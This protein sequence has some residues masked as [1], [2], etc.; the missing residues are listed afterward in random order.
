M[1][2]AKHLATTL[3]ADLEVVSLAA[4]LHDIAKPGMG[5]VQKHG[6]ASAE[7]AQEIL[8]K[9]GIDAE[10]VNRVCDTIRKHVGLTLDEPVQPLE[11]QVLWDADKIVKLG[12]AGLI[13][14]LVNGLKMKPGMDLHSISNEI[15]EFCLLAEKITASMNTT[16]G[17]E[18]ALE[19]LRT[20]Q[21]LGLI[22]DRELD[23]DI[24][25]GGVES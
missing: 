25:S 1:T 23:P 8:L 22:L 21:N 3:G 12:V 13:H 16:P 11:A 24:Q 9:E 6:E 15:R 17:K 5:S 18:M 4:W 19:R 14:F 7:M 20:L 10:T 2:T